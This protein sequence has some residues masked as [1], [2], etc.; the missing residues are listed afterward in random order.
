MRLDLAPGVACRSRRGEKLTKTGT[1]TMYSQ[2]YIDCEWRTRL[3]PEANKPY[4]TMAHHIY[5][6]LASWERQ[7]RLKSSSR[8]RRRLAR[9]HVRDADGMGGV[10]TGG[11]VRQTT[12]ARVVQRTLSPGTQMASLGAELGAPTARNIHSQLYSHGHPREKRKE[13]AVMRAHSLHRLSASSAW[14][15]VQLGPS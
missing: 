9:S 4:P 6:L 14:V 8:S 1:L 7:A 11:M 2:C 12:N 3:H 15:R 10:A 13:N 5:H